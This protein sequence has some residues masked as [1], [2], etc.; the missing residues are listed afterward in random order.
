MED[1]CRLLGASAESYN[2]KGDKKRVS[3]SRMNV[4]KVI[5]RAREEKIARLPQ[6]TEE[7]TVERRDE[8]DSVVR[9]AKSRP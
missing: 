8:R 2:D 4:A 7:H 5:A 9:G 3:R 1:T 6:S